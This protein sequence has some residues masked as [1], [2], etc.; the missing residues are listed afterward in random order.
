MI[1][2]TIFDKRNKKRFIKTFE[3]PFLANYYRNKIIKANHWILEHIEYD[4]LLDIAVNIIL[5][6]D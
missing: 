1:I 2:Y 3:S 6:S 5:N 4:D